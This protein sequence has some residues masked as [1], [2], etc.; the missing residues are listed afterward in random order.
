MSSRLTKPGTPQAVNIKIDGF[1]LIWTPASGAINIKYQIQ[2]RAVH[3]TT[4]TT[5]DSYGNFL[6]RHIGNLHHGVEYHCKVLATSGKVTVESD[7]VRVKT[8]E[9]YD[10]L[11]I[12]KT[13]Q[14]KSSL[15]NRL[16]DVK[17][18]N[19]SK[20]HIFETRKFTDEPAKKSEMT[21]SSTAEFESTE[22][23]RFLQ[24]DDPEI[25]DPTLSVT[26]TCKLMSNEDTNIRVLDVPG[27]SDS[28]ALEKIM[29]KKLSVQQGNLQIVRWLV[30][31]QESK[32]SQLKV[33]RIVYFLPERGALEK[34]HGTLQ[35]ELQ[36][37][38]HFFGA[39]VFECMVIAA[40]L[41]KKYQKYGFDE[42]DVEKTTDNR[43]F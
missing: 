19:R 17:N 39:K 29:K 20:I 21:A 41:Q 12:G 30:G 16:L 42:E 43:S 32:K 5:I 2:Y 26:I 24:A 6:E 8:K 18:T 22:D 11:M 3:E 4:Y 7:S 31:V 38:H 35:E 9:Y 23:K 13:G 25:S 37:L 28:G 36:V 40:T 10:I 14:G 15:G 27:F 33:R 34:A 1:N